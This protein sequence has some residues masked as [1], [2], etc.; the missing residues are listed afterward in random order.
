[1]TDVEHG[2]LGALTAKRGMRVSGELMASIRRA[3][4][5]WLVKMW[6]ELNTFVK[7]G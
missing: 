4:T 1:M 5:V 3:L 7:T 6:S 2:I